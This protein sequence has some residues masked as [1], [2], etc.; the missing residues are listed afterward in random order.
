MMTPKFQLVEKKEA[1]VALTKEFYIPVLEKKEAWSL[2]MK[3][4]ETSLNSN[5]ETLSVAKEVCGECGGLPIAILAVATALKGKEWYAWQDALALLKNSNFDQIVD[6]DPRLFSSLKLSYDS[7]EP[8]DARSCFLLCSLFPEDAEISIEDLVI[9]SFGMRLLD[10]ITTLE[11]VRNRVLTLVKGLKASCLL[12]QGRDDNT[13]KMHDVIRDVAILI[14]KGEKGYLVEHD[15]KK[16]P[17]G[18]TFEGY[19]VIS[20]KSEYFSEIPSELGSQELHTLVLRSNDSSLPDSF[21]KGM[22]TNL[23]VLDLSGTAIKSLPFSLSKLVKLRM[24]LLPDEVSDV[25]LLGELKSLEILRVNGIEK[26]PP[27]IRQLTCLKF[28]DLGVD[29][30]LGVISPNVISNLKRLEEL[31]ISYYFNKWEDE[32]IDTE[33]TNG[34]VVTVVY[35]WAPF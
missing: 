17:E 21:F 4:S 5:E 34:V 15:L 6:I 16:W 12:L 9:Y 18:G 24:L 33:G 10:R 7:L 8:R 28:L 11:N 1:P 26:L 13:V 29:Y 19:S 30:N 2:F 35:V 14:A 22:E 3:T 20:L 32:A 25:S 27:E 31:Y 23:E